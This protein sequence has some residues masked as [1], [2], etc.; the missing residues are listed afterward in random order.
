MSVAQK[1]V[2]TIRIL[3]SEAIQKANSGHPGI[4]IGAADLKTTHLNSNHSK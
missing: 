3:S 4:C 2:D 1:S